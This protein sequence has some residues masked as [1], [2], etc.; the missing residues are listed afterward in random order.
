M[1]CSPTPCVFLMLT[2]MQASAFQKEYY[3]RDYTGSI[4]RDAI[5]GGQTAK[6]DNVYI[7]QVYDT[8]AGLIVVQINPG[9]QHV[10]LPLYDIVK[11][12]SEHIKILCGIQENFRWLP[13]N[14]SNLHMLL[15][16]NHPVNGGHLD[17]EGQI[18]VGRIQEDGE[19][20]IGMVDSL[21]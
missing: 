5:I 8:N 21:H 3:W 20:K 6:G 17:A 10:F 19:T 13:T 12:S 7:G 15:L 11:N 4:P 14:S 2:V 16:Y 9:V 18:N 1:F